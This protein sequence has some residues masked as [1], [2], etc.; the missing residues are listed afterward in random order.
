M[1]TSA[2]LS[3]FLSLLLLTV[4]SA[5]AQQITVQK[6]RSSQVVFSAADIA[7]LPHTAVT[8]TDHGGIANFSGVHLSTILEKAGIMFGESLRGKRLASCLLV[9]AADNY[10]VSSRCP[11]WIGTSRTNKYFWWTNARESRWATRRDPFGSSFQTK[12]EWRDG[13]DR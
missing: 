2:L 13:C 10:R 7:A 3:N 6:D 4:A 8:V 1:K 9:E 12:N 11:N 5:T